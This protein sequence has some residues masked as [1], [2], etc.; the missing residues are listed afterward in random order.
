M[1]TLTYQ[2]ASSQVRYLFSNTI[3]SVIP[4]ID[5]TDLQYRFCFCSVWHL[6]LFYSSSLLNPL[7]LTSLHVFPTSFFITSDYLR[8]R[9]SVSECLTQGSLAYF[10]IRQWNI[11]LQDKNSRWAF[12]HVFKQVLDSITDSIILKC[13]VLMWL[14]CFRVISPIEKITVADSLYC[15][16]YACM[17]IYYIF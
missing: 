7:V 15:F 16:K 8:M 6:L 12:F 11:V 17:Y 14:N 2:S 4:S 9:I 1:F 5:H 10:W 13:N 3:S